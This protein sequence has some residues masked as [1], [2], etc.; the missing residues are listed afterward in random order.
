MTSILS[1]APKTKKKSY[2]NVD[3]D[4]DYDDVYS[5]K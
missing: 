1:V 5:K 3:G 2:S 4:D